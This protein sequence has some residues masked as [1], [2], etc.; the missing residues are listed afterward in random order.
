MLINSY[1]KINLYLDV[2]KKRQDDFHE[3][4]TLYSTITL[5][6]TL[7]FVL[8]KKPQIKI[9]SNI[10]EL[11]STDNL[12]YLVTKRIFEEFGVSEGVRIY[13][14]KRIPVSAGLGGGSSNAAMT[15]LA[16]DKLFSL[17]LDKDYIQHLAS[18]FGSDINFF[19]VGG[20]AKGTSRGEVITPLPDLETLDLLLVNP[21]LAISSKEAYDLINWETK[22]KAEPKLWFN[23][24]ES[25]IE[26]KYPIVHDII[27]DLRNLGAREASMSGSG[28]TC[29]GYFEKRTQQYKAASYFKKKKFWTKTVKTLGRSRY[30]E[31]SLNLS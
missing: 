11:A 2:L 10:Q 28:S 7:K 14:N 19:L 31:C 12:V 20:I 15:I 13:L 25:G 21:G 17:V 16:L 23:R 5:H 26:K 24:L 29:I 1:A 27:A 22:I 9:L 4:D 18:E 6:D 30:Q 8:T 3:V